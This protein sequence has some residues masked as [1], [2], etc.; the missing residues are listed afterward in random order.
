M[1]FALL[2]AG[3]LL[4]GCGGQAF[5]PELD[6]ADAAPVVD[7]QA[8]NLR[9][10]VAVTGVMGP[11]SE[12]G[13]TGS[14]PGE[15]GDTVG[16]NESSN[17]QD[18]FDAAAICTPFPNARGQPPCLPCGGCAPQL[19]PMFYWVIGDSGCGAGYT[20]A[21]CKD[22]REHYSC[23]CLVAAGEIAASSGCELAGGIL[24]VRP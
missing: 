11:T 13:S 18:T 20:P 21:A 2:I 15:A 17:G 4:A 5:E 7:V 3:L 23:E 10:E 22:C 9:D 24:T 19:V 14:S 12:G 1:N 16:G 8:A 6:V